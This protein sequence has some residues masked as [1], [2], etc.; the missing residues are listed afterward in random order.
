MSWSSLT[1]SSLISHSSTPRDRH[2]GYSRRDGGGDDRTV[3][4]DENDEN[5]HDDDVDD[6]SISSALALYRAFAG[7][8]VPSNS[9]CA[10]RPPPPDDGRECRLLSA[11][12]CIAGDYEEERDQNDDDDDDNVY[13]ND[14]GRDH[15]TG[16]VRSEGGGGT[17]SGVRRGIVPRDDGECDFVVVSPR[18][19]DG[20][21]DDDDDDED[22]DDRIAG[23]DD[24]GN[25]E[26]DD[27]DENE[28][29]VNNDRT[30]ASCTTSTTR[31]IGAIA[32]SMVILWTHS[33]RNRRAS[34]TATTERG[35]SSN[36]RRNVGRGV[37]PVDILRN[38]IRQAVQIVLSSSSSTW[39]MSTYLLRRIASSS[40]SS[41]GWENATTVPLGH[42][43]AMAKAGDVTKVVL[44]GSLAYYLHST[45]TS[46]SSSS[47]S[48]EG[49]T[50]S[51]Q[52]R[53][54]KTTLNGGSASIDGIIAT[55]LERGCDDITT[56]PES[57]L[58]RFL[59]GPAV[60]T[61]PFA[62]LAA[63]YWT[64]RRLQRRQ[65]EEDG[66]DSD[67]G[68]AVGGGREGRKRRLRLEGTTTF[69]DVAGIDQSL[70]ELSE[71]VSYLR[72]PSSFRILGARPP[73][74]ILLHGPPGSGKT[75]I[76]RAIAGEAGRRGGP[77]GGVGDDAMTTTIDCFAVCSG[78]EFVDTYVGRG[79]SRVR[80]LFRNVREEAMKN[81]AYRRRHMRGDGD[82][83]GKAGTT[84]VFSRALSGVGD[85]MAGVWES[86]RSLVGSFDAMDSCRKEDE[87]C[88]IR[89]TAIIFI[90]EI[91]CLAKRRDSG[92]GSSSSL[93][94]GCDEREQTLNQLL[95]EMDGFD[96]G[97]SSPLS[98]AGVVDV[99]VIA[100]TNRP[101]VLDPAIMRRFDR[102]VRVNL[103]DARGREAILRVHAR[104]VKW[105]RSSVD[106]AGLPTGGF[107]GADLKNV[108]N[109]AA[110]L[111]VR[112]RSSHVTQTHLLEATRKVRAISLG[113]GSS[114]GRHYVMN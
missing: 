25:Y 8:I 93:G 62:Y 59:D 46:L 50:I 105:D 108:I 36:R 67:A 23:G 92:M 65:L 22:E 98:V 84:R 101:E 68:T 97:G 64:M 87:G 21:D 99:I 38:A 74:G 13:V 57:L 6:I 90:D 43:L 56:L 9:S 94:G 76:A 4:D 17:G 48:S 15:R 30:T 44:R 88:H 33:S 107:S 104:R 96:T 2:P 54:S 55:L 58:R 52:Q 45:R 5:V 95:T 69:D 31:T 42:L 49:P 24:D 79:A 16:S 39:G 109:E 14:D 77:L 112:C 7:C 73:M 75:L 53:W 29:D 70:H 91:D 85:G 10:S 111:A 1:A 47:S 114:S 60:M 40:S 110:L 113:N 34:M 80:G 12:K 26:R 103:P 72:D 61:L 11:S 63:L 27:D 89:P 100:A 37:G 66:D 20:H 81:F 32:L 51:K 106:F 19:N 102:H 78:S 82:V 86:V 41:S 35:R 83:D 71:V 28:D 3:N 18:P